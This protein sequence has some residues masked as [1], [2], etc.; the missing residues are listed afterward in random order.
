M[1]SRKWLSL[2]GCAG[3]ALPSLM[4]SETALPVSHAVRAERV[5]LDTVVLDGEF[6]EA[7]WQK[8][9]PASGFRQRTPENGAPAS[10]RT[11]VRA[12]YDELNIYFAVLCHD[13][14]P[15]AIIADEQGRDADL[16]RNDSIRIILDTFHDFRSGY[17]FETNP[18]GARIDAA[19]MWAGLASL[20]WNWD[21]IWDV[22]AKITDLGWQAEVRIPFSSLRFH[23]R[24][25]DPWGVT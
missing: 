3:L 24:K 18:Q 21:E 9:Q 2:L 1:R 15:G 14:D 7:V 12:A 19:F 8:A 22:S 11:E 13:G 25:T 6:D 16:Y 23:P 4:A 17:L 10:E 20:N 5:E